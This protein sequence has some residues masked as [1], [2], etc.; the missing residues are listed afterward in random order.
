MG[1]HLGTRNTTDR[2]LGDFYWPGIR[3]DVSR[4]CRSCEACQKTV[5]KGTVPKAPLQKMPL[6]EVSFRRVAVDIAGPIHPANESG[7]RYILTLIDCA[8]RYPEAVA[9]KAVSTEAVAEALVNVYSR[10]GVP[11]E[12]LS[13]QGTQF[14][15]GCMEEVARL[16]TVRQISTTP[17]HPMCNGLVER[18]N[19]TLKTMLRILCSEQPKQWD[20]YLNPLLF[21]YREIPQ[22]TTGFSPFE[23]LYGRTVRGPMRILK[24]AERTKNQ[25]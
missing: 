5:L 10:V 15:S 7:H 20:R 2:I 23:L 24:S 4:H 1:G 11:E 8:T 6:V 16:L 21:A 19:G 13:D 14:V 3:G 17:Y 25:T 12:I 9:L 22:E 18:F